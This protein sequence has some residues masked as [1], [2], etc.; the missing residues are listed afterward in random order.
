MQRKGLS[1][2][3]AAVLLIAFTMAVAAI[4]TAWV[5]NF[6]K[7]QTEKAQVFEEQINCAYVNIDNDPNF[8]G[9]DSADQ[10][11]R[12]YIKNTGP[13][14]IELKNITVWKL[15]SQVPELPVGL[16]ASSGLQVDT[17]GT[18]V[19]YLNMSSYGEP[20]RVRILTAC[21]SKWATAYRPSG[22]WNAFDW[23]T[24]ALNGPV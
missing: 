12:V 20:S 4:L 2:L 24:E 23:T 22:G 17:G 9:Y 6:T 8:A 1:P 13:I 16:N 11:L 3:I 18:K 5:S 7:G 21:D 19:V 10:I 14:Q 15:S